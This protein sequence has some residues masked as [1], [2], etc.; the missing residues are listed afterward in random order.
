MNLP[1]SDK[2]RIAWACR[3]GMLELDI[4]L[5]S[6]LEGQFSAL[7]SPDKHL[8][9]SLLTSSDQDLFDWF[10]QKKSP[11]EEYACLI[12]GIISS[13]GER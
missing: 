2:K 7:S 5:L 6:F 9:V 13:R 3:R 12:A 11:P 10:L 8:F 4:I 1:I